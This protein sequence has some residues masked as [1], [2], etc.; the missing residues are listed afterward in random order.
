[1]CDHIQLKNLSTF[2]FYFFYFVYIDFCWL[3]T[4]QC[5]F[6]PRKNIDVTSGKFNR[7]G[8]TIFERMKT[9]GDMEFSQRLRTFGATEKLKKDAIFGGD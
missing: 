5:I 9:F 6:H 1:M 3:V 8:V 4:I 7:A 2:I